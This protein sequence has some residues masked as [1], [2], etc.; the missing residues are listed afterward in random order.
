MRRS[1]TEIETEIEIEKERD[2]MISVS[3]IV[4]ATSVAPVVGKAT[5]VATTHP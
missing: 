1:E 2:G 4:V 5:E 3:A